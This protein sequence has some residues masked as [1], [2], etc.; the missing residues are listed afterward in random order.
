MDNFNIVIR[1]GMVEL[2]TLKTPTAADLDRTFDEILRHPDFKPGMPLLLIDKGTDFD[3]PQ[4]AVFPMFKRHAQIIK[5]HFGGR[6]AFAVEREYHYGIARLFSS[7]CESLGIQ[8]HPFRD[9]SL[10]RNWILG[11]ADT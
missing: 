11:N 4:S 3:P 9:L 8:C 1:E 7:Y 10:A 5:D 6:I 2:E